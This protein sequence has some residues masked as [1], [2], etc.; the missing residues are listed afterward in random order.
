MRVV[1]L[2][3]ALAAARRA[4]KRLDGA[5]AAGDGSGV[6]G[7]GFCSCSNSFLGVVLEH[8]FAIWVKCRNIYGKMAIV[9]TDAPRPSAV[10][11]Q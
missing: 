2:F 11:S 9:G 8:Y 5:P 4:E 7:C 1:R 6:T 10:I 3:F